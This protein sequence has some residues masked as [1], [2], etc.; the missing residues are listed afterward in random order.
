MRLSAAFAIVLSLAASVTSAQPG[1]DE[2]TERVRY[3]D[4]DTAHPGRNPADQG[5]WV[6]L[7]TPTPANHGTEFFAVGK[8]VG[9]LAQLRVDADG[10]VIVRRVKIIFADGKQQI[11]DVD[12]LLGGKQRSA[13]IPLTSPQPIDRIV[14]TTEPG[15][16]GSY[17]LYGSSGAGVATR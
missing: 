4:F 13:T 3:S 17:A 15:T 6:Q 8:D 7:A 2:N 16:K 9:T 10:K 1:P 11:V 14:V 12:R 5:D